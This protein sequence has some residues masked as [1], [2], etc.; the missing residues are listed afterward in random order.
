MIPSLRER[1]IDSKSYLPCVHLFPHLR[2]LG[3]REGQFPVAEAASAHSL[4]LPFFPAL[5]GADRAGLRAGDA[6]CDGSRRIRMTPMSR[7]RKEPDPR[8]WR[9]NRSLPF[10]WQLA[11]YDILQSQAHAR[12]LARIGVLDEAEAERIDAGLERV[13]ARIGQHGF[14]FEEADEDIHMAIERLLGEEIGPLAGKLHTGRSRND[15]VATDIAMVVQAAL[16]AGDRALRRRR[17]SSCSPSPRPTATGR[18]PA[19]PTCSAPSPSTS[20]TTCSPTSGCSPA[21]CS[22]SSSPLDSAGVMPLG[23][24]ALAGVNWQIDRETVAADLGFAHDHPEL[25]RRHLQPRLRPR[26]PARRLDLRDAPLAARLGDRDLVEQ[27]VRLLRARRVLLLGL[28][29][30]AAE[31]EP[32]LGRAAA[33]QEPAGRR[34]LRRR[35]SA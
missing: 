19:T 8:F 13:R 18:C 16:A 30:H 27:R 25:D 20:A 21:T 1:G 6:P 32:R 2:E 9:M 28:L 10:D 31:G 29:D 5:R 35:C 22:A 24:G 3:Y 7:F 15:Q 34:R 14:A 12:G 26:L 4:A 33:R 11:P 23:S 17:W